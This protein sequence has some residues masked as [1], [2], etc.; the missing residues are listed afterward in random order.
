LQKEVEERLKIVGKSPA[1]DKAKINAQLYFSERYP[2]A[3]LSPTDKRVL[4]DI[5]KRATA[6]LQSAK[7]PY[8]KYCGYRSWGATGWRHEILK[9]EEDAKTIRKMWE[10]YEREKEVAEDDP[11]VEEGVRG[12]R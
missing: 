8:D 6:A 3:S 1:T 5:D 9:H 4:G 12:E 2:R 11:G 10:R 7:K